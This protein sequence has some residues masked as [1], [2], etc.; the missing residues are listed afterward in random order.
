MGLEETLKYIIPRIAAITDSEEVSIKPLSGLDFILNYQRDSG[1]FH[2]NQKTR[3]DN[4]E[5]I[6]LDTGGFLV[7]VN[8]KGDT[9]YPFLHTYC[10]QAISNALKFDEAVNRSLMDSLT[11]L[12][13]KAYLEGRLEEEIRRSERNK[14]PLCVAFFDIDNFKKINDMYGHL[15]GDDVLKKTAKVL[16]EVLRQSD[17]V[18]RFGGDEFVAILTDTGYGNGLKIIRRI[19]KALKGIRIKT[20]LIRITVSAGLSVF[21]QDGQT[22]EGLLKSADLKM[23]NQ[24]KKGGRLFIC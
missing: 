20:L 17:I 12:P 6:L 19:S 23:Y 21:P 2:V 16:R 14:T 22:V 13:N 7:L 4:V 5:P 10:S 11:G 1:V 15:V 18:T 8:K 24:K 9:K 3:F